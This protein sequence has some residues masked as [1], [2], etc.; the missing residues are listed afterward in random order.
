M[1]LVELM[2]PKE[3]DVGK[4]EAIK[5]QWKILP[6]VVAELKLDEKNKGH[7][8]EKFWFELHRKSDLK[9]LCEFA[10]AVLTLP[11]SSGEVKELFGA[12]RVMKQKI[13]NGLPIALGNAMLLVQK[14]LQ[15][16]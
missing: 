16:S 4:V 11:C 9:E 10:I 15:V 13:E 12:M 8:L 14:G 3:T 1:P 6:H 5:N 7:E 2:Y